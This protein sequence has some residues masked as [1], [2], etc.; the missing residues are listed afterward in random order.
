MNKQDFLGI[1][2]V[3]LLIFFT[4]FASGIVAFGYFS[5]KSK[6]EL[7]N[8]CTDTDRPAIFL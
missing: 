6:P 2:L 3:C 7:K 5:E 4:G 1:L 8:K